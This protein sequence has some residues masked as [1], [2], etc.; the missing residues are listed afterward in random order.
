MESGPRFQKRI[1]TAFLVRC[2]DTL[3]TALDELRLRER[4]DPLY[5]VFRAAWIKEFEIIVE[6]C[7]RFL[8]KR[9]RPCFTSN[10]QA[11]S[12]NY[13]NVFRLAAKHGLISAGACRRWMIYRDA[14][15]YTAH[16]YGAC[17]AESTIKLL[18]GFTADAR[19]LIAVIADPDHE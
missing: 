3:E 14:R 17:F 19:E 9:L 4:D 1:D 15:N 16:D 13:K 5:E 6:Q 10:R 7:G 12:L 11:N 2:I 8:K 18:P